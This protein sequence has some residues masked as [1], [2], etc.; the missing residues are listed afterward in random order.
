MRFLIGLILAFFL[1]VSSVVSADEKANFSGRWSLNSDKSLVQDRRTAAQG[2][3]NVSQ[4]ENNLTIERISQTFSGRQIIIEKLT[5]DGEE[6][7]TV[8]EI[9]KAHKLPAKSTVN[10]L[11]NGK[12]LTISSTAVWI[13]DETK[14][15]LNIIEIWNL[16]ENG[17]ILSINYTSTS[18]KG[19][20]KATYV[21]D[22][23]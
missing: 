14:T 22:R 16:S 15:Q 7:D 10:W 11:G 6:N 12:S 20:R 23:K 17:K 8:V 2:E 19:T 21:Y 13:Q 1:F 5:L 18:S 3:L 9:Y 4:E